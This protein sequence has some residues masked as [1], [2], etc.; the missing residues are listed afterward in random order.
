MVSVSSLESTVRIVLG[1]VETSVGPLARSKML[2]IRTKSSA[3]QQQKIVITHDGATFMRALA[4]L[5]DPAAALLSSVRIAGRPSET[6]SAV[7]LLVAR[8]LIDLS[9]AQERAA[10]DGTTTVVILCCLFVL[11]G[12]RLSAS[13]RVSLQEMARYLHA[14]AAAA[15][16]RLDCIAGPP[17]KDHVPALVQSILGTKL[18]TETGILDG[19]LRAVSACATT[20]TWVRGRLDSGP[21]AGCVVSPGFTFTAPAAS[22]IIASSLARKVELP[23]ARIVLYDGPAEFAG[24]SSAGPASVEVVLTSKRLSVAS[25]CEVLPQ[26]LVHNLDVRILRELCEAGGVPLR[27]LLADPP[28]PDGMPAAE[29]VV[30]VK[31][32]PRQL[33]GSSEVLVDFSIMLPSFQTLTIHGKSADFLD[34]LIRAVQDVF[35]VVQTHG[36]LRTTGMTRVVPGGGA[37]EAELAEHL[38]RTHLAENPWG[39]EVLVSALR[40]FPLYFEPYRKALDT[41]AAAQSANGAPAVVDSYLVKK[42]QLQLASEVA[43]ALLLTAM[44]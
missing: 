36:D 11:E 1:L 18:G 41:D 15:Q 32:H 44:P 7:D 33:P 35:D 12:L 31:I 5:E 28:T 19:V 34:E 30:P 43:A 25:S 17:G 23:A 38:M 39:S 14:A 4:S 13:G 27:Y 6:A 21:R 22:V 24:L 20:R 10:G 26:I 16:C 29:C 3:Q 8:M 9:T 2:V 42:M 37:T 40:R